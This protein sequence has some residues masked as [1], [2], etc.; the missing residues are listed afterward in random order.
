MCCYKIKEEE[1]KK[2]EE[3]AK[4]KPELYKKAKKKVPKSGNFILSAFGLTHL[5]I[6]R[7][8]EKDD[9]R[10]QRRID[11]KTHGN[12]ARASRKTIKG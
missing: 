8:G 2:K 6:R 3:E 11:E 9:R 5:M 10:I 4:Q 1:A 7:G 12:Y